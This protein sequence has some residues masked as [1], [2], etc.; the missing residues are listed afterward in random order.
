[1][2]KPL[3]VLIAISQLVLAALT[4]LV[5]VQFATWMGL[6]PPPAD[7]AYLMAMLGTRFLVLG[8]G[9]LVQARRSQPDPGW[10]LTMA[11]IQVG[12]FAAGALLLVQGTIAVPSAALPMTNAALFALGLW[13]FRPRHPA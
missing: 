13:S 7:S 9:L 12:D 2:L 4:L 11:A 10:V 5:P 1:M 8:L 3:L 6:T